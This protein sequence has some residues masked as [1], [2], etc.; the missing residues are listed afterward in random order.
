MQMLANMEHELRM[1]IWVQ[2]NQYRKQKSQPPKRIQSPSER[3]QFENKV[4]ST[5][6][7]ALDKQ[8]GLKR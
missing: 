3:K 7:D 8:L 4:T 2:A 1:L 6:I 5:D